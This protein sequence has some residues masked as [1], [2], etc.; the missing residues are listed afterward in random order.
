MDNWKYMLIVVGVFLVVGI[1]IV[2]GS[3]SRGNSSL[4]GNVI[5]EETLQ[6]QI[7]ET[8][9]GRVIDVTNIVNQTNTSEVA[10]EYYTEGPKAAE[11]NL[12][13]GKRVF[14]SGKDE[15]NYTD[16]LAFSQ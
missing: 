9:D 15:L 1:L 5:S 14:V 10:V 11:E 6:G 2:I 12:A 7:T 8:N 16:I 4:T 3:Q 13:N